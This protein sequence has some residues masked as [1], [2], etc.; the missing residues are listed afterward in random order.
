[1]GKGKTE[2]VPI[3]YEKNC[4]E[5]K[6]KVKFRHATAESKAWVSPG[7]VQIRRLIIVNSRAC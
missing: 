5:I 6:G 7:G 3:L 4:L 2:K 1:M